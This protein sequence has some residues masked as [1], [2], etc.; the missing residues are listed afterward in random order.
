MTAQARRPYAARKSAGLY[1][2]DQLPSHWQ[3]KRLK[4]TINGC[5]NGIWGS[6]PDGGAD[7][8]TCVRVADFDRVRF[9]IRDEVPTMRSVTR[10][11]R[12]R[13]ELRRGDLL[14]EK[15]GGGDLQP[16][17]AVALFDHVVQAV[18]SNFI[19]RMPVGPSCDPRFLSYLYASLYAGRINERS[20][21]QTTGIQNLDAE[22]YLSEF[23]PMPP[24]SE[25]HAIA[26][27][28]DRETSRID[29]L[30]EKKR[31]LIELLQEKRA[32]VI[33][34]AVMRGLTPDCATGDTG[35][36]W[37]GSIPAHWQFG[38]L[39]RFCTVTDCKHFTVSFVDEGFPVASVGELSG[40]RLDL[41]NAKLTTGREFVFLRAGRVPKRGDLV[42]CR[43]A[44]VG[45][46]GFVD[47][48]TPFA[49][50]QDV[51]LISSPLRSNR[52]LYY[53]LQ[54]RA[55]V[56]QLAAVMV[57]A[58]FKR[59]NVENIKEFWVVW[60]S[61]NE[62]ARIAESLDA[63]TARIDLLTSRVRAAE[64]QLREYRGSLI[65]AA[66]TGQ[67]DVREAA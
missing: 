10:A 60:P 11:E 14:L 16:V 65:A 28:L 19:A 64:N 67:I 40:N 7:D 8:V 39:K 22:S 4:F 58:T 26:A 33:T 32:A 63:T 6:E 17:G 53:V 35:I 48:D 15:S 18:C 41:T 27:F 9:V 52:F 12:R 37:L 21:K 20:I 62:Q 55:A 46:V 54:S 38:L 5:Y 51:C 50:G 3:V 31:R 66:V 42:Y 23:V 59:I 25:Q 44:S 30:I 29:A 61:E 36:P 2:L 34:Q 47:T 13:R 56:E 57:G 24:L 45:L 1:W 43:N 49:L